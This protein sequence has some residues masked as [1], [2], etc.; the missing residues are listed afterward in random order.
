MIGRRLWRPRYRRV[1]ALLYQVVIIAEEYTP[2]VLSM[3]QCQQRLQQS[4][5]AVS[6]VEEGAVH[7]VQCRYRLYSLTAVVFA[8]GEYTAA[9]QDRLR[10]CAVSMCCTQPF[11]ALLT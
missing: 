7:L 8:L 9:D 4:T 11:A 1:D 5:A 10:S 6:G 3:W 2:C